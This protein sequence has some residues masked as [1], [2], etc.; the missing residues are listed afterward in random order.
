M[1]FLATP[2][3][4]T[5]VNHN[6]KDHAKLKRNQ[7]IAESLE[8]MGVKIFLPQRD[9]DQDQPAGQV[10]KE[11]LE[12]IKK[13]RAVIVV[14][15]DTR[16]IYIEAGYAKAIGKKLIGLKVEETREMS[17]W[18][19]EFFDHVATNVEEAAKIIKEHTQ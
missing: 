6:E 5:D 9:V 11:E 14:L 2:M 15:S 17:D 4:R 7:E 13:C 16:G 10:I 8:S 18:G 12:A 19:Y 3:F 1:Y